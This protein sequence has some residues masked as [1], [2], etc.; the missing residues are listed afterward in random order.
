MNLAQRIRGGFR[1]YHALVGGA[2]VT[3]LGQ[4]MYSAASVIYF[5][6]VLGLSMGR[7]GLVL[8]VAG[9]VGF[10]AT[11]PLGRLVDRIGARRT[12]VALQLAKAALVALL[13]G[14]QSF[15]PLLITVALLGAA[16]RGG[17][18]A[19]Q[20]LV[21]DVVGPEQRVRV[22]ALTRS[23]FNAGV[24]VGVLIA[25]P[26]IALTD[27]APFVAMLLG[28]ALCYLTVSQV[29]ARLPVPHQAVRGDLTTRPARPSPGF[30]LL[31][32]VTGFLGLH[33]TILEVA[34]PLWVVRET[35]V[36]KSVVSLLLFVNTVLVI[37]LQ[38]PLSRWSDSVRGATGTLAAGAA[39][40]AA[41]CAVFATTH[42][43]GGW[44]ALALLLAATALLTAGEIFQS[45]G[46]W[47]LGF[48]LAPIGGRGGHL[49]AFSLGT[50]LQDVVGPALVTFVVMREAPHGWWLLAAALLAAG[51][52]TVPL[53]RA[54][55]R[56]LLA[57]TA[58]AAADGP[59]AQT[60]L[61]RGTT[62]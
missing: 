8:S 50:A 35:D 40:V 3:A 62:S 47:G 28:V 25:A 30:V 12:A 52:V 60:T 15:W 6:R 11:V 9:A 41:S 17:Q 16:T 55:H 19:W 53:A 20:A 23:A 51:A 5:T 61:E 1:P 22:Q 37:G 49:G 36:A 14:V 10:L 46:S 18:T 57:T 26:V 42:D 29:T 31:G 43:R 21:A 44:A 24:S 38:V 56:H 4:G 32:F 2:L 58:T 48:E 39:A 54:A 13:A 34:V 59:A 27:R 7:L 33:I 45:A